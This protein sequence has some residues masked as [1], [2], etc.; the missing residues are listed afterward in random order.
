[1]RVGCHLNGMFVGAFSCADDVTLLAPTNMTLKILLNTCTEFAASHNCY[2]LNA[3]KTKCLYLN[4]PRSQAPDI[5]EL[6]CTE[7]DFVDNAELL[8]ASIIM[9]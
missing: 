1:M 5:V 7:I 6:M 4:G 9:L 8:R 3:S 2:Y